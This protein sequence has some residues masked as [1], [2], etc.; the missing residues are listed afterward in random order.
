MAANPGRGRNLFLKDAGKQ[1]DCLKG[2]EGER[3]R[4]GAHPFNIFSVIPVWARP[5]TGGCNVTSCCAKLR[6][7]YESIKNW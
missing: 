2:K 3:E 7:K 4:G 5:S 6:T 1:F